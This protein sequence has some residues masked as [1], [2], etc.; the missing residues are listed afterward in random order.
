MA[1][2]N[3]L[4]PGATAPLSIVMP[5]YNHAGFIGE[6][7]EGIFKQT[8]LPREVVI[9]DDASTDDSWEVIEGWRGRH[10]GLIRALRNEQN[11]GALGNTRRAVEASVQPYLYVHSADDVILPE[12]VETYVGLLDAHPRAGLAASRVATFR[13][14]PSTW[15]YETDRWVPEAGYHDPE[16]IADE[17]RSRFFTS[18]QVMY[19]REMIE[20]A[21]GFHMDLSGFCDWFWLHSAAFRHGI[22]YS[23]KV[24]ALFRLVENS[25]GHQSTEPARL[26]RIAERLLE[27]LHEPRNAD[28]LPFFARS[29]VL[30]HL[31]LPMAELVLGTP[32][33]WTPTVLALVQQNLHAWAEQNDRARLDRFRPLQPTAF[34]EDLEARVAEA[35][36]ACQHRDIR[37]VAIYG[38]GE[39]TEALLPIW[40]RQGGPGIQSIFTTG[41]SGPREL[42]GFT[43]GTLD[44]FDP[45][46]V[47]AV[48]LSSRTYE[49]EMAEALARAFPRL[50]RIGLWHPVV[51]SFLP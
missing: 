27:I 21:G 3:T 5:N 42:G 51:T 49:M 8:L 36:F 25:L 11:L 12:C 15:T 41:S 19:R 47:D 23:P 18:G 30:H 14:A 10:P 44:A 16:E 39:V 9:V 38:A 46:E 32:R 50:P 4:D 34:E 13:R 28:L 29:G 20:E 26:R 43:L 24:L 17:V 35:V 33:W 45:S 40:R 6:A 2:E 22:A 37:R 48:I 7:L 31:G 1:I